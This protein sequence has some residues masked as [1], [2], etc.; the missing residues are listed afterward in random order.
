[1]TG[2]VLFGFKKLQLNS[3][4]LAFKY[5]FIYLLINLFIYLYWQYN[6]FNVYCRELAPGTVG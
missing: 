5:L 2:V 1:M 6:D 3:Y 4:Q